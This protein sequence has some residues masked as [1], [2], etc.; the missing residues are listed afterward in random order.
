LIAG[1]RT[2][3]CALLTRRTPPERLASVYSKE[4]ADL[5]DDSRMNTDDP[6]EQLGGFIHSF[7]M[8]SFFA[9]APVSCWATCNRAALP[10][11]PSGIG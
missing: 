11:R 5:A 10:G 9:I 6:G 4:Y 2:L 8:Q 7:R 1:R 3:P